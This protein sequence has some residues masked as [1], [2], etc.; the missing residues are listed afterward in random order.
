MKVASGAI[1]TFVNLVTVIQKVELV[2]LT[3][4]YSLPQSDIQQVSI[5]TGALKPGRIAGNL[6][7]FLIRAAL[8]E[9]I[10]HP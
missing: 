8:R 1:I 3:S 10:D 7:C 2:K 4:L 9:K 5:F 6:R